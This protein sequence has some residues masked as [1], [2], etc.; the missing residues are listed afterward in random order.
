MILNFCDFMDRLA[1][2]QLRNVASTDMSVDG[3]I[4]PEY[5]EHLLKLTNQGLVDLTTK[6]KIFE[7]TQTLTFIN[8]QNIYNLDVTDGA[9]FEHLVSVFE[10]V[11]SDER[12]HTPK[13]N[14]HIMQP[15]PETLR[16][17]DHFMKCYKPTIDVRFQVFHPELVDIDSDMN[18]PYHLYEVLALYVSGLYLAHIGGEEHK[19]RGDSYYGLYLQ[20]CNEDMIN[21]SSNT[22][23]LTDEDTRFADRG[24]V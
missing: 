6:K 13:N 5:H 22:S 21:N 8:G 20:K 10:I 4:K 18:L 1:Q 23:E 17:S 15:N 9:D 19:A 12:R 2:G 3:V 7:K 11:T 24:F 14:V 16:F